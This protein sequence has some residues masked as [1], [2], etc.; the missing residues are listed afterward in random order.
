CMLTMAVLRDGHAIAVGAAA[1]GL[2][3][4][5]ARPAFFALF[6]DIVPEPDRLRAFTLNYW[7]INLGFA[8]AAVLAGLA[9]SVSYLVLFAV[10]AGTT[11]VTAVIVLTRV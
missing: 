8:S 10:D 11:L 7:A 1:L 4:E 9:A 3:T 2:A 5:M 6:V